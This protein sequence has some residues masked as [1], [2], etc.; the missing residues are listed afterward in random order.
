MFLFIL[1]G[2]FLIRSGAGDFIF[3]LVGVAAGRFVG[4]L[5]RRY[6]L[7]PD[8]FG[9]GS[10]VVT[11]STGTVTIPL[12]KKAGFPHRFAAGV[13]ASASTGGQLMPPIMVPALSSWRAIPGSH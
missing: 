7:Q 9:L 6:R 4:G 10:A 12:M 5:P 8:G 11:V 2:A 13:E 3:D 1:F